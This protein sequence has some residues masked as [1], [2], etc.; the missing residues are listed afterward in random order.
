LAQRG[1]EGSNPLVRMASHLVILLV[2]VAVLW[3]SRVQLPQWEMAQAQAPITQSEPAQAG[4][5]IA[6]EGR[7]VAALERAALP[8]T[9][10]PERPRIAIITHT[11]KTGDTLYDIAAR[12]NVEAETLV[13]ANNMDLNPDLLRLGQELVVLPVNGVYHT[14]AAGDTV[15]SIAKKYKATASAIAGFELN[16]LDA[17]NPVLMTGQ[18]VIVPGGVKPAVVRQVQIYSGPV[19]AGAKKGTGRFVWPT[20]GVITQG[21]KPLHAAVDIGAPTGTSVRASD[22]GYVVIAGWSDYGY[23]YYVVIDHGNGYQTLYAHL[24]RFFVNA[25]DV[26]GQGTVIGLVGSTGRSSGPHLHFEINQNGIGRN[27]INLLP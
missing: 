14:V 6:V 5:P 23:G 24:S 25:G 20:S 7:P 1:P 11:V 26:V 9:L 2:A 27:P 13:W 21:Y 8:F 19:P 22:T 3:F 17:R 16:Q 12:Y 15:E 10:V 18:K 4:Q